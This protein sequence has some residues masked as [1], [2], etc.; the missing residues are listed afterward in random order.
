MSP[1]GNRK[2]LKRG[3]SRK[4]VC[5]VKSFFHIWLLMQVPQGFRS[6]YL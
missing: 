2:L 1:L 4:L 5:T 6:F 3:Q